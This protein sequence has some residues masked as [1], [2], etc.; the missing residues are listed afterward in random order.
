MKLI[1]DEEIVV[2]TETAQEQLNIMDYFEN[3]GI[4]FSTSWFSTSW[5]YWVIIEEQDISLSTEHT[6]D[7]LDILQTHYTTISLDRADTGIY[8]LRV[9]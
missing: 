6:E 4:K 7:I 2:Y 9:Q 1:V 3:K 5:D 8:F